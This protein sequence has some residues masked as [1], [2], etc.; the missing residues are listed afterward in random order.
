MRLIVITLVSISALMLG[1]GYLVVQ[2]SAKKKYDERRSTLHSLSIVEIDDD[3]FLSEV[4]SSWSVKLTECPDE[5][6]TSALE[7]VNE[8]VSV[9]GIA[10]IMAHEVSSFSFINNARN[11]RETI[12]MMVKS[13]IIP[14][15]VDGAFH[16]GE[17]IAYIKY[18]NNLVEV[19]KETKDGIKS[20][21]YY[22][23]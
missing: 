6:M 14:E 8:D 5:A 13:T 15:T 11:K 19:Y 20:T 4:V 17:D 2:F 22:K 9:D 18:R 1:V 16:K 7:L 10:S 21:L 3:Q 12:H 23:K